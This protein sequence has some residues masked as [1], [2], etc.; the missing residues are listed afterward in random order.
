MNAQAMSGMD[1][2]AF[3]AAAICRASRTGSFPPFFRRNAFAVAANAIASRSARAAVIGT[4]AGAGPAALCDPPEAVAGA[5][6]N[7]G[8]AF[9][10]PEAAGG[11][12]EG[13]PSGTAG[14]TGVVLTPGPAGDTMLTGE[15]DGPI[16]NGV[17][18]VIAGDT[19]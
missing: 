5:T 15:A 11:G 19:S 16:A 10:G 6:V 8:D 9:M 12:A 3:S 7:P 4:G 18:V 2:G 1:G 14:G 13:G 17:P